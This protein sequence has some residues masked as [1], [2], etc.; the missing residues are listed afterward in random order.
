MEGDLEQKQNFLRINILERGCDAE[1]F[2]NFLQSKKGELGLDLNNWTL[3]EL[4]L[5]VQEFNLLNN[6]MN[7]QNNQNLNQEQQNE[8]EENIE[9][10]NKLIQMDIET[11]SNHKFQSQEEYIHCEKVVQNELLQSK[12]AD[13]KLSF[14]EKVDGGIF[15]KS[16]VTYLME[17]IPM[18]VKIRKR[19][20]DFDWLK[21]ILSTVYINCVIP[22]LCKKNYTDRFNEVLI[23]KRTRAIEKFMKGILIH[24]IMKNSDIFYNFISIEKETDFDKK[25][26]IYNRLSSPVILNQV[27]S[28]SGELKVTV[29]K[30]KE[31]YLENI[32]DYCDL[33]EE[34]FQKITKAYKGLIS[35]MEQLSDKMKEISELW[36]DIYKKNLKYF[37][38]QNTT[39]SYNIMSKIMLD[40]S[41][42]NK[43]QKILINEGIREYF[44]YIKNE[45]HSI[46]DLSL[47]VDNNHTIY[48]KAF[49][50]LMAQ[51]ESTFKQDISTWGLTSLDMENK[52]QLLTNKNLAYSKMLPRDTKK[53]DELRQKY[54]F[55]LNSIISEFERIRELNSKRHK[56]NISNFSKNIAESLNDFQV[57]LSD[58]ISYYDDIKEEGNKNEEQTE[59]N[60]QE[61]KNNEDENKGENGNENTN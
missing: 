57:Y 12:E 61:K 48:V 43:K 23:A 2:M 45:F 36:K 56:N 34:L 37:E 33:N 29:S 17:T 5:A 53:V 59:D 24:P 38:N 18:G 40:W 50:K 35:L 55:Y 44:R 13:I 7:A 4:T 58:R 41:E 32:K 52:S 11:N 30:E 10:S 28:L 51:K 6:N 31:I 39:T 42:I 15:S 26:K 1:Q 19:Y 9:N 47:K 49:D 3:N 14:P 22:P 54:G 21:N 27:K 46:K 60:N 25:K 20:S 8:D 16:Y